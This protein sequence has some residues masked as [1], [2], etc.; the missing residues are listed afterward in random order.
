MKNNNRPDPNVDSE[1]EN[2]EDFVDFETGASVPTVPKFGVPSFS[3]GGL[4][5]GQ[6]MKGKGSVGIVDT[7]RSFE[8]E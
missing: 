8:Q 1:D 3:W 5:N 7:C 6:R 4:D 2:S